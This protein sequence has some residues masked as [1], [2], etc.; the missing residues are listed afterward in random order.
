[1]ELE[2]IMLNE[3]RQVQKSS[4]KKSLYAHSYVKM[5]L[6]NPLEIKILERV[7]SGRR[8]NGEQWN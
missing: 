5:K 4:L 7:G 3:I 2:F 6:F 8:R 1:M